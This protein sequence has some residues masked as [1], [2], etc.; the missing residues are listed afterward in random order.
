MGTYAEH[1]DYFDHT[2]AEGLVEDREYTKAATILRRMGAEEPGS[3][4][5][6]RMLLARALS[7]SAQLGRAE[8]LLR[9][10][11]AER[12]DEAYAQLMLGRVLQRRGRAQEAQAPLRLAAAM[13]LSMDG[14][15][16]DA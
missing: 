16:A 6:T 1:R 8:A 4:L 5:A 2:L 3:P 15:A 10:V 9:S 12:P 14:A 11:V 7:S 13:G